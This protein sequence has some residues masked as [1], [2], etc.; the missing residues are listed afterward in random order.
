MQRHLWKLNAR[1]G[2]LSWVLIEA[3]CALLSFS[4]GNMHVYTTLASAIDHGA[5]Q[6]PFI[7]IVLYVYR[8]IPRHNNQGSVHAVRRAGIHHVR[9][10]F[11]LRWYSACHQ[12]DLRLPVYCHC[13]PKKT[14]AVQFHCTKPLG[15]SG[16]Q[17]MCQV[18]AVSRTFSFPCHVR[19]LLS[20]AEKPQR[21]PP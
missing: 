15:S 4:E 8:S 19:V 13:V 18:C 5:C 1:L 11:L 2:L 20:C 14:A 12:L 9:R 17:G 21:N 10:V 16:P 3:A 7:V 6:H